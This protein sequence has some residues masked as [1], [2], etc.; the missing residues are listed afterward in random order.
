MITGMAKKRRATHGGRRKGAGRPLL[1]GQGTQVVT[2][3]LTAKH[4]QKVERWQ[5][6]HDA[7]NFS[8]AVRQIVDTVMPS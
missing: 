8:D 2:V 3:R 5:D 1:D 6:E 4:I 7:E